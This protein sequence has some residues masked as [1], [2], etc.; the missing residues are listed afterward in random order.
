MWSQFCSMFSAHTCMHLHAR[1]HT[2]MLE[3]EYLH[4]FAAERG[5]RFDYTNRFA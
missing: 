3:P 1:I 4:P 5:G 2:H